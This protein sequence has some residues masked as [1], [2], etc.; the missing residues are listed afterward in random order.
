MTIWTKSELLSATSGDLKLTLLLPHRHVP[1]KLRLIHLRTSLT[2]H[3]FFPRQAED[4]RALLLGFTRSSILIFCSSAGSSALSSW[5]KPTSVGRS[6]MSSRPR[7]RLTY[8]RPLPSSSVSVVAGSMDPLPLESTRSPTS[9]DST[10]PT[11]ASFAS[12]FFTCR[13]STTR[14]T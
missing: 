3:L 12:F 8:P 2:S 10:S 1:R 14:S 11:T 4:R 6:D 9:D 7:A 5:P 13:P